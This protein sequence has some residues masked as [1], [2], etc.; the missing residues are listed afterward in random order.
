MNLCQPSKRRLAPMMWFHLT[1][2]CIKTKS[3]SAS[4]LHPKEDGVST[5]PPEFYA[6]ELF[7]G[8]AGLTACMRTF[9]PS[10]FGVDHQVTRPKAN[11]NQVGSLGPCITETGFAMD[12][13]PTMR[14]GPLGCAMWHLLKSSQQSNVFK[15]PRTA[16]TEDKTVS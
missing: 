5:T 16:T 10:S 4:T 15:P 1:W 11:C 6:V 7:C 3:A 2:V 8:S 14:M 9:L 13:R 12:H